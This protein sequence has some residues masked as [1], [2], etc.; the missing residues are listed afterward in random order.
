MRRLFFTA[1]MLAAGTALFAQNLDKVQ[2]L[3]SKKQYPQAKELIDKALTDAKAQKNATAWYYKGVIYNELAKD[4]AQDLSAYRADAYEA[5]KKG[6]EL[7]PKNV[8]GE[9]EQN[10]RMFDIYNFYINNAIKQH[11]AKDYTAALSNY[12][13]AFDVQD[14]INKKGFAYNNQTLPAL[15]TTF[16]FYAGNAAYLSKDTATGIQ[17]FSKIADAKVGG[18]DYEYVYQSLVDYYNK[19]GDA[20]NAAKYAALGKE[21]YPQSEYWVYYELYDPA[22]QADKQ[23]LFAKYEDIIARNPDKGDV[24]SSYAG[25]YFNYVY[26]KDKPADYKTSQTKLEEVIGKSIPLDKSGFANFLMAQ[27]I[28]NQIY[29]IQEESRLVKGTKTEDIKKINAYTAQ[30]NKKYDQMI[31]YAEAAV[32]EFSART[33][34]KS[35]DKANYKNMLNQL[36]RYFKSKKQTA[37]VTEYEEKLKT[38]G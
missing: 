2:E 20:A 30:I 19:K 22:I 28:S 18:K 32:Q 24:A 7:D 14:Y 6:Q 4:S 34:L 25:E 13:S 12:R 33:D 15:D 8:M 17:Y 21:I 16:T 1:V 38:L 27:H 5:L 37:K 23:K 10:W 29:D 36:V 9:L 31:P 11:N 26:G 35:V 3:I